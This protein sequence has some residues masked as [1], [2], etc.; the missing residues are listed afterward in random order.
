MPAQD[1]AEPATGTVGTIP[2]VASAVAAKRAG[3]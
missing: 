1:M 2:G 3:A